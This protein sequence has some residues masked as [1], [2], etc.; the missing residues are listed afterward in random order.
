MMEK[1]SYRR[2]KGND[3]PSLP[4]DRKLPYSSEAE[5]GVIGGMLSIMERRAAIS[6]SD[7]LALPP[8][9]VWIQ[10]TKE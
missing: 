4:F 3:P 10:R 6:T 2:S 8:G 9:W 1:N 5:A 7:S